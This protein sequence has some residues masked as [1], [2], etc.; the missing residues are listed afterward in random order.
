MVLIEDLD[1][2]KKELGINF[3]KSNTNFFFEF[4]LESW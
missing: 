2:Q 3:K 1:Q 4:A